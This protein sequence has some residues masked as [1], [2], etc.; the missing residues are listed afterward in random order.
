MEGGVMSEETRGLV[1]GESWALVDEG[2][3]L[4]KKTVGY[5]RASLAANT[6]RTYGVL[7]SKFACWC[8]GNGLCCLPASAE[9]VSLYLGSLGV[10]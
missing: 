9:T 7:W 3:E 5:E 4:V 8:E 2:I 10:G 6:R 1:S